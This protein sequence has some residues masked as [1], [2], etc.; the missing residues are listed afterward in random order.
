[1]KSNDV[2]LGLVSFLSKSLEEQGGGQRGFNVDVARGP[3]VKG[4]P[5]IAAKDKE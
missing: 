3:N 1:M 5:T 4:I 2:N